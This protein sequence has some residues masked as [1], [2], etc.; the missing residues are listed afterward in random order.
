MWNSVKV[1]RTQKFSSATHNE[2]CATVTQKWEFLTEIPHKTLCDTH[3]T[4]FTVKVV[5]WNNEENKEKAPH[6]FSVLKNVKFNRRLQKQIGTDQDKISNIKVL[7]N[8]GNHIKVT[9]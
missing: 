2:K 6:N 9:T 5:Q 8:K 3:M 4:V 1:L 7:Y